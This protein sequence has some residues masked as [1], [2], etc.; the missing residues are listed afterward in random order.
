MNI[1]EAT[2]KDIIQNDVVTYIDLE[3]AQKEL[4]VI[5]FKLPNWLSIGD[6]IQCQ[7]KEASVCISKECPGEVSIEN[8]I[9]GRLINKRESNSLCETTFESDIGQIVALIT[10]DACK[11]LDLKI[12][13]QATMLIRG[14]DINLEPILSASGI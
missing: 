4:R 3:C 6:T 5:K 12:E 14:V 1:L 13:C 9:P 11:N 7:F 8:K 10:A 2:V